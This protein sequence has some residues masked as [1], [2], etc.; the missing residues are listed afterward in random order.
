VIDKTFDRIA[1]AIELVLAVAFIMAV[2]L[3]FTNVMGRYLFGISFL[4]SDAGLHRRH[5]VPR[6][7]CCDPRHDICGW[8]FWSSSC[9]AR[10]ASRSGSPNK[11]C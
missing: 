10:C 5:D 3:N 6:R 7:C 11:S 9:R 1:R 2:V 8:M 4:A